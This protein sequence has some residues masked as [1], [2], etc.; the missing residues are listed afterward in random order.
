MISLYC[1]ISE[2]KKIFFFVEEYGD[3]RWLNREKAG[4]TKIIFNNL[5]DM[6]VYLFVLQVVGALGAFVHTYKDY[7]MNDSWCQD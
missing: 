3:W 1:N 5:C 4:W 7:E 6:L 2:R